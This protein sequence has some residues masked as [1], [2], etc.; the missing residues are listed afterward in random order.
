MTYARWSGV[1]PA[2]AGFVLRPAPPIRPASELHRPGRPAWGARAASD[3]C[4]TSTHGGCR[5]AC[6]QPLRRVRR[7]QRHVRA[8]RLERWPAGRR[9]SP[10]RAPGRSPTRASGPRRARAGGAPGG[11]RAFSSAYVSPPSSK[12]TATAP[13]RARGL[14]SNSSWMHRPPGTS[15]SV[16]VPLLQQAGALGLTAAAPAA[17][18]AGSRPRPSLPAPAAGSRPSAPPSPARRAPSRSSAPRRCDPR[19]RRGPA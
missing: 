16:C 13:R 17:P 18:P 12:T 7:V 1:S 8:A 5:P 10:G 19:S 15:A 6:S 9:P 3:D 11:S 14:R 2:R 4:V